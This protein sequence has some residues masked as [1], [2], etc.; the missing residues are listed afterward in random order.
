[1]GSFP[2]VFIIC[3]ENHELVLAE[4]KILERPPLLSNVIY[5]NISI[6]ILAN[7]MKHLQLKTSFVEENV[8]GEC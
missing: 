3:K 7:I 2:N 5:F 6:E 1:M 4:V 8:S